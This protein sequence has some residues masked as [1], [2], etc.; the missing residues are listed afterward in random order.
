MYSRHFRLLQIIGI[1][2]EIDR[3]H[4][5]TVRSHVTLNFLSSLDETL[6]KEFK[7]S[8]TCC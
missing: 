5:L 3:M 1:Q 2:I 7:P 4:M 6:E 8:D